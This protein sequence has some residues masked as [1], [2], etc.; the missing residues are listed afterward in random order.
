M[1]AADAGCGRKA[2]RF[3]RVFCD[4]AVGAV[5][6][7]GAQPAR[8]ELGS[9]GPLMPRQM[10]ICTRFA[11]SVIEYGN[12]AALVDASRQIT[13]RELDQAATSI[14]RH[15]R[16]VGLGK[17]EL[18]G[19][20]ACRSTEAIAAIL[21]IL[22][23]GGAYLPFDTS[24]PANLLR[25]IYDDG[26]PAIM[27]AQR[28]LSD[29]A[30]LRS[31]WAGEALYLEPDGRLSGDNPGGEAP[32][33]PD[34]GERSAAAHDGPLESA[35]EA[36]DLAYVMYTSGS[37]GRPKGVMIP[38]RGVT[39]LV[40]DCD[41]VALGP[42]E[43]ILHLAPLSFDAST[44]EIW[45][46]LL[47]GGKL[48]VVPTPHPSL[49]EIAEAICA[50]GVTTL[51]L[52]A[53]LFNLMV[54][55]RLDGLK[56]LRQLIVG[57]DVLSPPHI[58]KALDALP[59][60]RIVNGYGPTENTTFTCCYTIPRDKMRAGSIPIGS[61]IRGTVAHVLDE[62]GSPVPG[63][64][65]GELY[66][67]GAGVAL[68]YLNRPELTAERFVADPFDPRPGAR[69]YRTGDRVRLLPDG[70]LE[71][72]GRVDRQIKISGKRVELDE[73]EACLRR[74]QVV[75][76]AAVV[77]DVDAAGR[78]CVTAFVAPAEG[79]APAPAELRA[80]LRSELPDFMVPAEI[81]VLDALPLSPTGKIDRARLSRRRAPAKAAA[82][83]RPLRP[84]GPTQEIL[85]Q[86]W[87]RILGLDIIGTDDNFFDLGGTSLQLIEAHAA[88]GEAFDIPIAVVDLFEHPNIKAL[89][90]KIDGGRRIDQPSLT[91]GER[92]RRRGAAL[93]LARARPAAGRKGA[94]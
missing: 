93:A 2:P 9:R 21:G 1:D 18:V 16:R 26:A 7:T 10:S 37:T 86:I 90:A 19:L 76:D 44:F 91:A 6:L 15:L 64:E 77:S 80:F 48:A 66:A 46:A 34:R 17:G 79:C 87:G 59:G 51:W 20:F 29:R 41:F 92:A 75:R 71:F 24:Y 57:G 62:L 47:N 43:V 38:H 42:E 67:G 22:K 83:P 5:V 85:Q 52:T 32:N 13:Y 25:Y 78:R 84:D 30:G 61:A 14:A 94:A 3:A 49:D 36:E 55:R 65:E 4:N 8:L 23:A 81:E 60:C 53:G 68:G 70:N 88:I 58:A 45:G 12:R 69:I 28:D 40:S 72:L 33:A 89:A 31:F 63:G 56:P 73:I 74:S 50:Y 54:E 27:L 82:W 39:R 35:T 11:D